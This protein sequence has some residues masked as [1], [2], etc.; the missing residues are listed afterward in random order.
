MFLLQ[1][2]DPGPMAGV[3]GILYGIT[4]AK[5]L[6]L[7]PSR[8]L[9][10]FLVERGFQDLTG[11]ITPDM[12]RAIG[13]EPQHVKRVLIR[14]GGGWGDILGITPAIRGLHERYPG[15]EVTVH[16]E[17]GKES[18]LWYN[19]MVTQ[20]VGY[21]PQH[22]SLHYDQ[23]DQVFDFET[24]PPGEGSMFEHKDLD[25][26]QVYC[27]YIGV[28]PST[29]TPVY[30]MHGTEIQQADFWLDY[31]HVTANDQI[32]A[33]QVKASSALRTWPRASTF[34]LIS[35]LA[36]R[37]YFVVGLTEW[38]GEEEQFRR[39]GWKDYDRVLWTGGRFGLRMAAA[40]VN[41]SHMLVAP[42]SVFLVIAGALGVPML[43]LFGA[44]SG[45]QRLQYYDPDRTRWIQGGTGLA[46][47]PCYQHMGE[48]Q[49]GGT[50]SSPCMQRITVEEVFGM[51]KEAL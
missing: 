49:R 7:T 4:W 26:I 50:E 28:T 2:P 30:V 18:I 41:R 5:G 22:L 23:F 42:D 51:I 40:V 3:T 34:A 13:T 35:K 36:R 47:A 6:T 8:M 25:Y 19:S 14:R 33:V 31:H 32:V 24:L 21:P 16:T 9:R 45:A 37:G 15:V 12:L 1:A 44:F 27:K 43:G 46:C 38:P 20:V 48:C 39:E 10:D 11:T 17:P 29:Y